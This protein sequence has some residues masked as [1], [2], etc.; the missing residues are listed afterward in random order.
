[1]TMR[2]LAAVVGLLITGTAAA[3]TAA[4]PKDVLPSEGLGTYSV[5]RGVLL[6]Y[7]WQPIRP[8]NPP[9]AMYGYPEV[10][11]I[12]N[13]L[14]DCQWRSSGGRKVHIVLWPM[15]Q[16]GGLVLVVAPQYDDF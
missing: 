13:S 5:Y 7:G 1:M 14:C 10:Y 12:S 2:V 9:A 15:Y 4:G 3:G 6:S 11:C 16:Q 8:V